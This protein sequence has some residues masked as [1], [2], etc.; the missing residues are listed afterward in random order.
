MTQFVDLSHSL[1]SKM[2]TYP[3]DPKFSCCPALTIEKD[4]VNV[5][6]LSLGTHSG[7]H[8]DAPYHFFQ[9]GQ[10]V[11]NI[12]L[13]CCKAPVFVVDVTSKQPRERVSWA[14]ISALEDDLRDAISQ[15]AMVLFQTGWSK[16]W[17]R[18][19]Y[20]HHPFLDGEV[21]RRLVDMGVQF[22]G[23]D[24]LSP[25]ET[26]PEAQESVEMDF[27]VHKILLSANVVIAENL[28]NLEEIRHGRWVACIAPLKISGADGSP[29]RAF[30]WREL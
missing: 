4:E 2:S 27:T 19:A 21:A 5:Q 30:A 17:G 16:Y 29:V 13:S 20:F 24:T 15:G 18:E 12:M 11:D 9:D 28:T 22:I 1:D 3:G 14:D 23:I 7:T 6:S 26:H 8:I 10:T 25:D